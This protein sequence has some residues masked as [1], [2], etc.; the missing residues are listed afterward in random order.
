MTK[1]MAKGPIVITACGTLMSTAENTTRHA[2]AAADPASRAVAGSPS[3]ST[4]ALAI[5][6]AKTASAAPARN[7]PYTRGPLRGAGEDA[8]AAATCAIAEPRHNR[9]HK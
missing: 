7:T 9:Q 2:V 1:V 8:P 4:T 3:T 6:P 5:D